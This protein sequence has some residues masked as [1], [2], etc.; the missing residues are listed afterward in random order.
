MDS[1]PDRYSLRVLVGVAGLALFVGVAGTR[2][3][4]PRPIYAQSDGANT[5]LYIEP[6]V[7]MLRA[8]DASRQVLGKV[9]IDLRSGNVWGFPTTVDQPYP[10]DGTSQQPPTSE[11]FLLGKYDLAAM[12]RR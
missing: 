2:L 8:P 5:S 4:E 9:V 10:V 6:G 3:L 7:R 11:P 1:I 12:Q